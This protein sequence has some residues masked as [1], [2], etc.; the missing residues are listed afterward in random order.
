M[1]DQS[2]TFGQDLSSYDPLSNLKRESIDRMKMALLSSSL[3]DPLSVVSAVKG[4]TVMRV[5]H[6][7]VRIVQY[8]DLMDRLEAKL[9]YAIDRELEN[10]QQDEYLTIS[11]LLKIQEQI[12]KS[13]IESNKLLAPY[14][15]MEQYQT[16]NEIEEVTPVS[17]DILELDSTK[18]NLLRENAGQIL[19]DLQLITSSQSS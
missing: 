15:E 13:I 5:Y 2:K 10:D 16:F 14:L 6:Q 3:D 11:K 12:Q 17:D 19:S 18:R 8:L 1:K 4:V 9:Y 7:V